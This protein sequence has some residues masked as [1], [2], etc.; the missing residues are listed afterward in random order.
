[1][2][3]LRT[4]FLL[5]ALITLIAA[6]CAGVV[7]DTAAHVSIVPSVS[8]EAIP[9]EYETETAPAWLLTAEAHLCVQVGI[10]GVEKAVVETRDL[11]HDGTG[12]LRLDA[13]ASSVSA[14]GLLLLVA[15]E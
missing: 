7:L 6:P 4:A 12:R 14:P 1:M 10:G 15:Y 3:R 13:E 5:S 8:V 11:V 9:W 2:T